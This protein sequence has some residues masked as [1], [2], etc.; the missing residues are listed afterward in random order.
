M[1]SR[2]PSGDQNGL[3]CG[4]RPN[5]P[6][7]VTALPSGFAVH[8]WAGKKVV[9]EP[10]RHAYAIRCPS[11]DQEDWPP[12]TAIA[13]RFDPSGFIVETV[14][15][16]PLKVSNEIFPFCPRYVACATG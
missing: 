2:R 10:D 12:P 8:V 1:I 5:L 4:P 15:T 3:R 6:G 11:G 16:P 7:T 13:V 9:C 14:E